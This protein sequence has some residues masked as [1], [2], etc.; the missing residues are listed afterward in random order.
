MPGHELDLTELL[1]ARLLLGHSP[2]G[3]HREPAAF[4]VG[5]Q[6]EAADRDPDDV[7]EV[8]VSVALGNLF[9]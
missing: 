4:G 1:R 8:R 5:P 3:Q 2:P 9:T 7:V 6:H